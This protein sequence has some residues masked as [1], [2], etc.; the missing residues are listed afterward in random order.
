MQI[1]A[2]KENSN[3]ENRVALTPDSIKLFQRLD[4]EV[5]IE[6]GA[7]ITSGYPNKL[8]EENGAKI[9]TRNACLQA[10]ICLCVKMPNEE[11]LNQLNENTVLIVF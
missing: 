4:L 5:L 1:S 3:D 2:L 8:Y 11:D 10:N 7:G 6:D 9:V